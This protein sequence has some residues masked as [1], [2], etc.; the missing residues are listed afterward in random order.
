MCLGYPNVNFKLY[1]KVSKYKC[2]TYDMNFKDIF[3]LIKHNKGNSIN[4]NWKSVM[5][6][7]P[8]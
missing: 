7:L 4:W 8:T 2:D 3:N 1:S 5:K 6:N